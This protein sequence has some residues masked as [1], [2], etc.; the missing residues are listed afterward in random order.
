MGLREH[1]KKR[2]YKFTDKK[3]SVRGMI[4]TLYF[5]AAAFMALYAV[6]LSFKE[7]G[8]AG[9]IVGALGME[10]LFLSLIGFLIGIYSFKEEQVFLKFTWIGTVGNAVVWLILMGVILVGI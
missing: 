3:P 9:I 6:C 7:G 4:S 2:Q 1:L 5:V 10:A 8:D